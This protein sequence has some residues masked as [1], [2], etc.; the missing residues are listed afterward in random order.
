[1]NGLSLHYYTVPRN[2]NDKGSATDFDEREYFT[3]IQKTLFMEELVTKHSAIMDRYDP[4]KRVGMIIDEWGTWYNVE[5]GTN[6]GFLYQQNTLRDAIVAG[7]NLNIFNNHSDRVQMANLA[8]TVNVLQSVILTDKEKM[9]LT[10]TY[11]VFYLYKVHQD[12]TL[13]PVSFSGN[14]YRQGDREIEAVSISAS[15]N[16][17]GKI[18]IT[19]V[20]AD[21]HNEQRISTQLVGIS[22][23]KVNGEIVTS[24]NINDYNSFE[25]PSKVTVSDF[26]GASLSDNGL[27]VVLPPKAVVMLEIE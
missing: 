23:K 10:P 21:P 7:I 5:P 2:W 15:K 6:P 18:H 3:T 20:N 27:S 24:K 1:M 16:S 26:K 14:K 19:L 4:H 11:W 12:A 13:L 25:Q 8:Q 9:V 22:A 17:E